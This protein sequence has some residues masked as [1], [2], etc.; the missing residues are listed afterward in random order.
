MI[1]LRSVPNTRRLYHPWAHLRLE[2]FEDRTV[3]AVAIGANFPAVGT[4]AFPPFGNSGAIGPDHF[5]EVLT[6]GFVVFDR[7]G[8]LLQL[9]D[10]NVFWINAGIP[11]A[12]VARGVFEPHVVYDPLSD[13]WFAIQITNTPAAGQLTVNKM[14]V[15]RSDTNDPTGTWTALS[16]IA[17]NGFADIPTLAVDA[18]GVYIGTTNFTDIN[19]T[20]FLSVTLTSIPK[21][22]LLLATPTIARRTTREDIGFGLGYAIQG[23]TNF[24]TNPAHASVVAVDIFSFNFVDRTTITGTGGANAQFGPTTQYNVGAMSLPGLARQPDGSRVVY[25]SD[26]EMSGAIYQV[27]DLIYAVNG[28][29]VDATG[30]AVTSGPTTTDAVRLTVISDSQNRVVAESTYFNTGFDYLFPSVSANQ[31]GDI[32]I[33]FNRSSASQGSGATD[34]NLG[35]YAVYARIDPANPTSITFGPEVQLQAGLVNNYH[36]GGGNFEIWGLY[37]STSPDP[38]N[39]L[40]FWTTQ[41]VTDT[42]VAPSTGAWFTQIS[43]IF[44]S[45]RA[46]SASSPNPNGIYRFGDTIDITVTFNNP[47]NVLG[48]PEL[49]LNSGGVATF[50]DGSGTDTLKFTYT[51]ASGDSAADLDYLSATALNLNGGTIVDAF[52][53]LDAELILPAPGSPG[54][55]GAN[56]N[57][58]VVDTRARVTGVSSPIPD[59]TYGATSVIAINVTFDQAMVV[60]GTPQLALNSGGV[61]TYSIGSGTSTLTFTY[62]VGAGQS[63]P[64]LDYSSANAL[65]LNGGSIKDQFSGQNAILTL[66][67]PGGPGSLGANNNIK[68]DTTDPHVTGVSSP[69]ADGLY[70]FNQTILITVT[71]HKAVAVSG[72][73][74]LALNSGG[75]ATYLSGSGGTVLTFTYTVGA[76]QSSTDLDYT[77]ENALTLNGGT[78]AEIGSGQNANL[79]L[80]A[81]GAAGSLGANKNIVIDAISA[82]V[83]NVTSAKPNGLYIAGEIIDITVK[84]DKPVDVTGTPLLA[85]NSGGTAAY[86]SGS[87]T[88]TLTFRYTVGTGE[89][90]NDLDYASTT[91]L[92]LNGGTIQ[93][94]TGLA[95]NLT[96][97]A[98]G[99][100]GSLGANKNIAID[101]KGP[102]VVEFRVLFGSRSYNVLGSSR[103]VLPWQIK[104][105]QVVF[106]E[107]VATGNVQ[108]L[109]GVTATRFT[110][111]GTK[112]LTWNFAAISNASLHAFLASS[113]P[114]ALKDAAGNAISAFD[115]VVNVLFG[116]FDGNGFVNAA[117][118]AGVRANIAPPYQVNPSRYNIFADLNGDGI[119]NLVDVGIAR[120]KKGS[121]LPS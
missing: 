121:S 75:T 55:L 37:S 28:I 61:A 54:S 87:G 5:V 110:G 66:P 19:E 91:A 102:T 117:D 41:E 20:T 73:P 49:A 119:V 56:K 97:P 64:D 92:T 42:P 57:I 93:E 45:P 62:T 118:E 82:T 106:D 95:A 76:G 99:S 29:S 98:P 23:V 44:V 16:Y 22:D 40:A 70:K 89:D 79:T 43:Q 12:D 59:G 53:E 107:P 100:P 88:D 39:P 18:N 6:G 11:A 101:T 33:G 72:T 63:S 116:D 96:L 108:S 35:A 15:A 2:T 1:S 78:I 51:V 36:Q 80:P 32:V 94:S 10:D 83:T 104:G 113:G 17:S 58:V 14:L 112:V 13:T 114:N 48:E 47:V 115:Q 105:F 26:H 60:T 31:Y 120:A 65:T 46:I 84:F 85:L 3:P 74:Q 67:A 111:R 69:A 71:F 90:T 50:S 21:A 86:F 52:S 77:S 24:N 109:T 38:T 25:A 81:P 68:I 9:D 27:G 34:G 7:D 8:N 4:G 103:T 30:A